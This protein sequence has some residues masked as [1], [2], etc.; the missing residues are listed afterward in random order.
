MQPPSI[1]D[2]TTSSSGSFTHLSS[3]KN[4]FLAL[5]GAYIYWVSFGDQLSTLVD[6]K[7]GIAKVEK[8]SYV[9]LS[10]WDDA[11]QN[12]ASLLCTDSNYDTA[13]RNLD[14][15]FNRKQSI[16]EAHLAAIHSLPAVKKESIV[17]LRKLFDSTNEHLRA[18]EAE[19]PAVDQETQYRFNG[20]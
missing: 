1:G 5:D 20:C 11:A 6:S 9:K 2:S 16:V 3:T 7:I 17:N 18:K 13:K 10:L 19:M 14:E 4:T 15:H 8:L 12:G